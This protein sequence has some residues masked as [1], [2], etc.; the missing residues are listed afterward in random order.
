M[1]FDVSG[2]IDKL[3]ANTSDAYNRALNFLNDYKSRRN[4]AAKVEFDEFCAAL[5]AD[6][7]VPKVD[8]GQK[9]D[10]NPEIEEMQAFVDG[11]GIKMKIGIPMLSDSDVLIIEYTVNTDY[12]K[13]K[14]GILQS[15]K[16]NPQQPEKT[17]LHRLIKEKL[18]PELVK[19]IEE[20]F[21]IFCISKDV[22]KNIIA[23][24]MFLCSVQEIQY[25]YTLL[26]DQGVN[27]LGNSHEADNGQLEIYSTSMF[28]VALLCK[29]FGKDYTIE[30][31]G[32]FVNGLG[33]FP[34]KTRKAAILK[35]IVGGNLGTHARDFEEIFSK[36][37]KDIEKQSNNV[38]T[39]LNVVKTN[40]EKIVK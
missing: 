39:F 13:I 36:R 9:E 35:A 16:N 18:T 1:E 28:K 31:L 7:V 34:S 24:F 3:K 22:S 5:M 32:T 27:Y 8:F 33:V 4:A 19:G 25:I 26:F 30:S 6:K 38:E 12:E 17:I 11:W 29:V 20:R 15:I 2:Y 10:V 21:N 14:S 37:N 40:P 23:E